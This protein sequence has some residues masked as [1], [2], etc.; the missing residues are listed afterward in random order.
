MYNLKNL[1]T[2]EIIKYET[3]EEAEFFRKAMINFNNMR[4]RQL[5]IGHK[6]SKRNYTIEYK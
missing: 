4:Y 6:D 3:L 1:K 2:G 5:G